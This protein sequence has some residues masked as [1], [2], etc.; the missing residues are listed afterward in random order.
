MP[1][2]ELAPYLS[3]A[4]WM[5]ISFG[6]MFLIVSYVIFPMME[7]IFAERDALIKKNLEIAERVNKSADQLVKNYNE[8]ILSAQQQK[9]A[10]IKNAY[11]DMHREAAQIEKEHEREVRAKIKKTEKHLHEIHAQLHAQS[12]AIAVD[13]AEKLAQKFYASSSADLKKI[14][15]SALKKVRKGEA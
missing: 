5:L 3:Q 9:A 2:F 1:Q 14:D 4:F 7:E 6:F 8:Y 11:E 12:D 10:M 13:I 15:L